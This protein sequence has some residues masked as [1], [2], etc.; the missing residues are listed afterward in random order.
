MFR[1]IVAYASLEGQTEKIAHH[2]ARQI[3]NH[4]HV[5]RLFN[6]RDAK[7]EADTGEFDAAIVAGS[8]HMGDYEPELTE[9]VATHAE[10]LNR[11]PG[12]FLSVSLS[13]ASADPDD[14]HDA[15]TRAAQFIQTT[16]WKPGRTEQV[17]GAVHERGYGF[18]K[19]LLVHAALRRKGVTLDESGNTEFTDWP[20]LD[21]FV[22]AFVT[23][24]VT[25]AAE[26]RST[27]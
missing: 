26:Q 9:F 19:R 16:G 21:Q 11:V 18:F 27:P 5:A 4:G 7:F 20:A 1:F 25:G 6:T 10:T 23:E 12:S 3:E 2:V 8:L 13:P 17:G 15:D 24:A 22:R 14:R